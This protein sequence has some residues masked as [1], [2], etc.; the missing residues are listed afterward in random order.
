MGVFICCL[1]DVT[2]NGI[3]LYRVL[4]F[5]NVER[6]IKN[7]LQKEFNKYEII[8]YTDY[9]GYHSIFILNYWFIFNIKLYG[10]SCPI[11]GSRTPLLLRLWYNR[12]VKLSL[13]C[14]IHGRLA[15]VALKLK[16]Q[17]KIYK[18]NYKL[19]KKY[20]LRHLKAL[21]VVIQTCY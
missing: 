20:K 11:M 15:S 4:N 10:L 19:L 13:L 12:Y 17:K 3:C 14:I 1:L 18:L 6:D 9:F 5:M 21:L 8:L 2:I 16:M 7:P